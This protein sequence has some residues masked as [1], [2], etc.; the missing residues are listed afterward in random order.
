[1]NYINELLTLSEINHEK[2]LKRGLKEHLKPEYLFKAYHNELDEAYAEV[3]PNNQA[4]LED[5]LADILWC[6]FM[7]TKRLEKLELISNQE[8]IFKKA[9]KKFQERVLPL[10]CNL[11]HDKKIWQEVK[12]KQKRALEIEQFRYNVRDFYKPFYDK[13]DLAHKIDHANSVCDLALKLNSGKYKEELVILAAYLH[14]IFNA[15]D[16]KNHHKLAFEYVLN[17]KDKFLQ[18]LSTNDL[19][20]VAHAI[21]EHRGSFKGNFYSKLSEIISSADRGEPNL[22]KIII[23]SLQFNKGN[24]KEVLAHIKNKYSYNG[25]GRY[26]KLYEEYFQKEIKIFKDK[27]ENLT[28]KDIENLNH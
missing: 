22:E 23:R 13:G 3:R 17:K 15:K 9:L 14:D 21:L 27:V 5:E 4:F 19:N 26:P 10:N 11:E 6:W 18:N 28:I 12:T 16:R 25:Y 8:T 1:M 7:T 2:D 20:L 24:A